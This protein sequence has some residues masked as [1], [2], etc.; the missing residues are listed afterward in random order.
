MLAERFRSSGLQVTTDVDA[1]DLA[2]PQQ[3]AVYHVAAEALLN[4]HRHARAGRVAIVVQ[5]PADGG[6]VLDVTDDGRGLP[7][8]RRAG[9]GL[10]TMRERA[11]ELGG[12]VSVETAA[13][14][15]TR[16]RMVLP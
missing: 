12:E 16:V 15:G 4:A 3:I 6:A 5:A 10:T 8:E 13:G 9:I 7:D 14:G 11:R 2:T 1:G